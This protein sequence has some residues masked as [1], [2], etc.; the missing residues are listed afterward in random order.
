[1]LLDSIAIDSWK[2]VSSTNS[3]K[4]IWLVRFSWT[5]F[6]C[7]PMPNSKRSADDPNDRTPSQSQLQAESSAVLST[8]NYSSE[9]INEVAPSIRRSFQ[10][11]LLLQRW[12]GWKKIC[13]FVALEMD[14]VIACLHSN[15][16]SL[17][18]F[19]HGREYRWTE[20][21][22]WRKLIARCDHCRLSFDGSSLYHGRVVTRIH[23][24]KRQDLHNGSQKTGGIAI[25]RIPRKMVANFTRCQTLRRKIWLVNEWKIRCIRSFSLLAVSSERLPVNIGTNASPGRSFLCED[26]TTFECLFW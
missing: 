21:V 5:F 14:L 4:S 24:R 10:F 6:H 11:S 22:Q 15:C 18:Q 13:F 17:D 7:S 16:C 2:S 25:T 8:V 23:A 3:F 1:M 20:F 19:R 9:P 12:S 26:Q